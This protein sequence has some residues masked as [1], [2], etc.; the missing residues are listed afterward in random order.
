MFT[1]HRKIDYRKVLRLFNTLYGLNSCSFRIANPFGEYQRFDR[2][3]GAVTVFCS[4]AIKNEDIEIW[5]DGSTSRDFIYIKDVI[6]ALISALNSKIEYEEI[7][8]GSG[9]AISLNELVKIIEHVSGRKL[10]VK[11]RTNR[12]FDV[13]VSYLDISKAKHFLNWQPSTSLEQ[14]IINTYNW[15]K[16]Q[17]S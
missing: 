14:G 7:N 6:G 1:W 9:V 4:K 10:S 8:I 2:P 5:G 11:Y 16:S 15:I 12:P 3:H 17:S 13:P